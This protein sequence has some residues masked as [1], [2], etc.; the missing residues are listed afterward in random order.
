MGIH[1]TLYTVQSGLYTVHCTQCTVYCALYTVPCTQWSKPE[2][3]AGPQETFPA[4]S[5]PGSISPLAADGRWEDSWNI[6]TTVYSIQYTVYSIQYA[7]YR[8]KCTVY[9]VQCTVY[10]LQST[11]YSSVFSGVCCLCQCVP[12][13]LVSFIESGTASPCGRVSPGV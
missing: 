6:T 4:C 8:L 10:S 1:Y 7:V 2:G 9:S 11:L 3:E 13:V 5:S 12:R